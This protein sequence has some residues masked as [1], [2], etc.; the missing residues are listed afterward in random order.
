MMVMSVLRS[1]VDGTH[2][3][4]AAS[5]ATRASAPAGMTSY[6]ETEM[7][8]RREEYRNPYIQTW[9]KSTTKTKG[10]DGRTVCFFLLSNVDLEIQQEW[11]QSLQH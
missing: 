10:M 4:A 1:W 2:E 11:R 9:R 7:T 8:I 5:K 3:T 6:T